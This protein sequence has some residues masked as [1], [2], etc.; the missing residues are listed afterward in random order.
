MV[1][2]LETPVSLRETTSDTLLRI[3]LDGLG[4]AAD[5]GQRFR[6]Y[7]DGEQDLVYSTALF[8]DLFGDAFQG[9]RDN[10][11]R[12]IIEVVLDRLRIEGFQAPD[13]AEDSDKDKLDEIWQV[14]LDNDIDE[15]SDEIIE[16]VLVEGRSHVIVWPDD[17]LG[18][19]ID[20][21]P[22]GTCAIRYDEDN[23][24][25]ALWAVKRWITDTNQINVTVYTPEFLY[26]FIIQEEN[27]DEGRPSTQD[28]LQDI[29]SFA[30]GTRGLQIREVPGEPWPLPNPLGVV[31][32]V[33]IN[34]KSYRS[35]LHRRSCHPRPVRFVRCR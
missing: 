5:A 30:V 29:P 1:L 4:K 27:E 28:K 15:L 12:P 20:W 33:E 21:Q 35:E 22:N 19:T 23:P 32:V 34:N 9:F 25:I 26:K 2:P 14:F 6:D 8:H 24:R 11:M 17:E 7:Y 10:W 18:A 13:T 3:E 16:G 31:P